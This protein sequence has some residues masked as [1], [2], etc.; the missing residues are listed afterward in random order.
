MGRFFWEEMFKDG[1]L[2]VGAENLL[3]SGIKWKNG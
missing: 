1:E 3:P 2:C